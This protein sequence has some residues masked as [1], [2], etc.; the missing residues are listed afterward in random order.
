LGKGGCSK[1]RQASSTAPTCRHLDLS[2]GLA[3]APA[4]P[5]CDDA[6]AS[7]WVSS[8]D[9]VAA[10]TW[11]STGPSLRLCESVVFDGQVERPWGRL[12]A[13]STAGAAF[14]CWV[15]L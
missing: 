4:E 5:D 10:T 6:V 1:R 2:G 7:W 3:I 8:S 12:R 15:A 14:A 9:R 11:R 13:V